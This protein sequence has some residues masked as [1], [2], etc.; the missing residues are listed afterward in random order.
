[1]L[2]INEVNLRFKVY[3]SEQE[4]CRNNLA[5]ITRLQ[6]CLPQL[7]ADSVRG[8]AVPNYRPWFNPCTLR[9]AVLRDLIYCIGCQNMEDIE[10]PVFAWGLVT[11]RSVSSYKSPR[12]LKSRLQDL[13]D[14]ATLS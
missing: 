12:D 14:H 9:D 8:F 11:M 3:E 2:F 13:S 10:F 1:M 4:T 6:V 7:H 5:R